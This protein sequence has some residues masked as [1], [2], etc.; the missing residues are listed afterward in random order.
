M[1]AFFISID[2]M[3]GCGKSTQV[4]MLVEW[5]DR[6]NQPVLSVRDP[7]GTLLGE[8]LREILLHRVEI[9]LCSTAEMLLYMASRSQLVDSVILPSLQDHCH[10]ISDRYLLANVVYQGIA[11][12]IGADQV[13]S[14]GQLA[15]QGRMPDLTFV[16]DL[17][18]TVALARIGGNFDRL[19]SR[20]V[21][22]MQKVRQGFIS[23]AKK[24]DDHVVVLDA[25]EQ[26]ELVHQ[27][28]TQQILSRLFARDIA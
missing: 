13:W 16:L 20:G 4:R 17:E 19:E 22:Y 24:L 12:G 2:G 6:L 1:A 18:P 15:I 26:P 27:R 10:V 25:S 5:F 9:P 14:I 3:D 11:G 21:G 28:I 23:E 7:G 8:K